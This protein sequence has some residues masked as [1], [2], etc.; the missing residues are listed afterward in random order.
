LRQAAALGHKDAIKKYQQLRDKL[1]DMAVRSLEASDHAYL[2]LV[3]DDL[4]GV[5]YD[6]AN[7]TYNA[8]CY[9]SRCVTLAEKDGKLDEDKRKQLAASYAGRAL[10]MLRQAVARGYKNVARLKKSPDLQPLRERVEFR[11]LLAELE[12]KYDR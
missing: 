10:A 9:L 7:D 12:E 8:A 1:L 2:A 4:A 6:P 3:A 11:K 5:G